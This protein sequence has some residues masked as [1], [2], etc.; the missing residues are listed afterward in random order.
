MKNPPV[1]GEMVIAKFKED[2][3]HYRAI[4]TKVDGDSFYI[5]YVDFG[6]VEISSLMDLLELP[7]ELKQVCVKIWQ[8]PFKKCYLRRIGIRYVL[9][10]L[11]F[12][13]AIKR[14]FY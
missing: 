9:Y 10:E 6:N 5:T 1:V 14:F 13:W 3:N 7:T 11:N 4:I 2:G 8:I 12:F